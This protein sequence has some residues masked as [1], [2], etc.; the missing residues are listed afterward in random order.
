MSLYNPEEAQTGKLKKAMEEVQKVIVGQQEMLESV[1]IGLLTGGHIL[2]EGVP[3]LAKTLAISSVSQVTSL[4]FK[5]VQFTPDLLPTDI[6]GTM[7]FNSM[8]QAFSIKKG[9]VFTNIL[10]AD[11]NQSGTGKSAKCSFGSDGGKTGYYR[12]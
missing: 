8:S 11:E 3:G 4:E 1:F 12:G 7:I 2:I 10:L 5:R 6:I 9:P